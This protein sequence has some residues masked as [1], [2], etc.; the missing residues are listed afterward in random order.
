MKPDDPV[1]DEHWLARIRPRE[2]G[3]TI[4]LHTYRRDGLNAYWALTRR[5]AER[6]ARRL[7]RRMQRDDARFLSGWDVS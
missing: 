4:T 1:A 3:Y 6:K 7:A 2:V 5:G